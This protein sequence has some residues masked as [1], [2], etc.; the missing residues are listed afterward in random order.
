MQFSR[1]R[2]TH[3]LMHQIFMT[4]WNIRTGSAISK[5]I[6]TFWNFG[7]AFARVLSSHDT[8]EKK[9]SGLEWRMEFYQR[10]L[11]ELATPVKVITFKLPVGL[12][13]L[14]AAPA[15]W[16]YTHIACKGYAYNASYGRYDHS[17]YKG[18]AMTALAEAHRHTDTVVYIS[19]FSDQ[20]AGRPTHTHTVAYYLTLAI[21]YFHGQC[22]AR[23]NVL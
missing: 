6:G 15:P 13:G 4:L 21:I 10:T 19:A 2:S 23:S 9:C 16:P 7:Y 5:N 17:L 12:C 11:D 3:A 22:E 18:Y 8:T 14:V 20:T 1:S